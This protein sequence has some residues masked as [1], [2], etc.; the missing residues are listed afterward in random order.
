M[1][2]DPVFKVQRTVSLGDKQYGFTSLGRGFNWLAK[3]EEERNR[4]RQQ[5]RSRSR[6]RIATHEEGDEADTTISVLGG[7]MYGEP[8]K[9]QEKQRRWKSE[10]TLP[11]IRTLA[12]PSSESSSS[13]T[14]TPY[15]D[16]TP[17]LSP[18]IHTPA[19]SR[20]TSPGLTRGPSA[21]TTPTS[22]RPPT[23]RRSS[24]KRVSLVAG[25]LTVLE[26]SPELS[27]ECL[28]P[29]SQLSR[30]NSQSSMLSRAASTRAPSPESDS[31]SATYLGSHSINDY[32]I[33][34]EAGRGAYGLVKR[35]RERLA[36]G[37]LGPPLIIK[38][39]IKSRILADCW[40]KH[41]KLGT[42]PIEIY[43]MSS[44]SNTSY[45]LPPKRAW[46][47][48]RPGIPHSRPPS[49]KETWVEGAVV[50]GHPNI[51]PLLDFFE[52]A[53][54]YYLVM[55]STS[56]PPGPRGEDLPSDL[57]DLVE[58][59]PQ[60]LPPHLIRSYL[61]Q[62]ADALCFLH[63]KGIV[64]R[65]I[66]DENVVLGPTDG[67]CILI[68]FGSSGI[69]RRGGWDTFSGTLDYAG[70]EILRGESYNGKEQDVWAFGVVAYVLLVGECPFMTPT[71]AQEGL[72]SPFAK[73][74][75]SLDE[76]CLEGHEDEG[77]EPDGG[78]RLEDAHRLVMACLQVDVSKR[79]TFE[80]ILTSRFLIG[81]D[82]W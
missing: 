41:P 27:G 10:S 12:P 20:P 21:C 13:S 47:P 56:P 48:S 3:E 49:D 80:K 45:V 64:H 35:A 16:A 69:V 8:E 30:Y 77:E 55:P 81:K 15:S 4:I 38:Q 79:P 17:A 62:M 14:L 75:I 31:D 34:G 26:D 76:R 65:D 24:Q 52:D 67:K 78:G 7:P 6:Q 68:D 33:N 71:E 36:D 43:V 9:Q 29:P 60:G 59:Y 37:S 82:G 19:S 74:R 73:A 18:P 5:S 44:I 32:V 1:A 61:G 54:F 70:P 40:K 53:H 28:G 23:R 72:S 42:I 39:V 66:K 63:S 2:P 46:D 50:Q 11:T 51:C 25:R 22:P 57:F 58:M